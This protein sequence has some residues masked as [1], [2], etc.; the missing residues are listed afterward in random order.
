MIDEHRPV[1]ADSFF[2]YLIIVPEDADIC[3]SQLH[4]PFA[5]NECAP[6]TTV[7]HAHREAV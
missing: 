7:M 2:S 4:E 5:C 3:F 1:V 6:A